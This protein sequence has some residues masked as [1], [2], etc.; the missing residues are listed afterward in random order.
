M[1][2]DIIM[3]KPIMKLIVP[4]SIPSVALAS[5]INSSI[6]TKNM[7]PA[8]KQRANGKTPLT[9]VATIKPNNAA[10]IS[11]IAETCPYLLAITRLFPH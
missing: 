6:Q 2:K 9:T 7:A 3:T 4:K 8:A 11:T 1:S 10:G 5:G